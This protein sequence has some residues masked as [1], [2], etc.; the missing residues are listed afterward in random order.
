MYIKYWVHRYLL[1]VVFYSYFFLIKAA[2]QSSQLKLEERLL[3]A[4]REGD[5]SEFKKLVS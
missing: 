5:V 3:S 1:T 4:A 2:E